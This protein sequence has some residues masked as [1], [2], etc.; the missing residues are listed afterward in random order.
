MYLDLFHD[1]SVKPSIDK[2]SLFGRCSE[3]AITHMF[4]IY[5][6]N[7][8]AL[9][10][11]RTWYLQDRF[12]EKAYTYVWN[13]VLSY[14]H[15][16]ANGSKE[17]YT[18]ALFIGWNSHSKCC[19]KLDAQRFKI[20]FNPNKF[21]IPDWLI[22]YFW[23]YDYVVDY[24]GHID[25]AFDLWGISKSRVKYNLR[26]ALTTTASIGTQSNKTD[27]IGFSDKSHNR[28]KIYDKTKERKPYV[29]LFSAV[30]RVEISLPV[31]YDGRSCAAD[32]DVA[33]YNLASEALSQVFIAE[34][35]TTDPMVY[36]LSCLSPPEQHQCFYLMKKDSRRKYKRLLSAA[37][38]V[39]EAS[40][41]DIYLFVADEVDKLM[42][43]YCFIWWQDKKH[44]KEKKY[45]PYSVE[46]TI[47]EG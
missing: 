28:I 12:C 4:D 19:T 38:T 33:Q 21:V 25:L 18:L 24:V 10:K 31:R 14:D 7:M 41:W 15:V 45:E 2:I 46:K 3:K 1:N 11:S 32:V 37:N 44:I 27:Y 13:Y 26:Y 8:I 6:G 43:K 35:K 22:D 9:D 42:K 47:F 23:K 30:T 29:D 40:P 39:L 5:A 16:Y 36:A 34:E 20:E 17:R